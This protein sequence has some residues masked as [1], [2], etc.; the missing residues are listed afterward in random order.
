MLLSIDVG[1][2][3]MSYVTLKKDQIMDWNLINFQTNGD[4]CEN[5]VKTLDTYENF[6]E[7]STVIIEKQP[8][9]NNKM[10]I[11]E[12]LLQS[13]FIIK[14]KCNNDSNIS[15]VIVYSSKHKLNKQTKCS[16]EFGGAS[17]YKSRKKLSIKLCDVFLRNNLKNEAF[18][19]FFDKSAKKDDLS[20]ALL[21]G[22]SYQNIEVCEGEHGEKLTKEVIEEVKLKVHSRQPTASQ[23]KKQYYTRS[24]LKWFVNK[25]NQ[26]NKDIK[27]ELNENDKLKKSCVKWYSSVDEACDYLLKDYSK[28]PL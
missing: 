11:I 19:T 23:K 6:H 9:K 13:Y 28:F 26:E 1:L 8:A 14:G 2:K 12:A 24:N 3:N 10:R 16:K 27:S 5:I 25:L 15:K 7:C 21:M 20:D 22:L 18:V 4:L 17:E